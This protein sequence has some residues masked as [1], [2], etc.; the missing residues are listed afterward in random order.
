MALVNQFIHITVCPYQEFC[1]QDFLYLE[2]AHCY[3]LTAMTIK[4]NLSGAVSHLICT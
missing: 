4:C 1:G 2:F 3:M